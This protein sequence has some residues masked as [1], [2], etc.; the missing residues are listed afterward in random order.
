MAGKIRAVV[1]GSTGRGNYGHGLDTVFVGLEGI[2]LVAI[3]DND[4]QG[5]QAAG[6]RTGVQRLYRDYQEMFSK[7]KPQLAAIGPRHVDQRVAMVEAAAS[8]GCAVYC[9]KPLAGDLMDADRILVACA[10]AGVPIAVAHQTHAVPPVRQVL[11]NLRAG[12][13]GKLLRMRGRGKED[14]RGGGED[15]LVLGTHLMDLMVLFAGPPQWVSGHVFHQGRSLE[16]RDGR[17]PTE[18]VGI[19]G[20]DSLSATYGFAQ[21]VLGYFE[22]RAQVGQ[23]GKSPYGLILE[24]EQATLGIRAGEVYLYPAGTAIPENT[25]GKWEKVWVEDWHFFPDHKPRPS[26]W[27]PRGN[28]I[29]ARDLLDAMQHKREPMASGQAARWC[30]EM[31]LGVYAS[32]LEQGRRVPLPQTERRHPLRRTS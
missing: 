4:P 31:I 14:S 22:S 32:H 27:I 20:G 18:P 12:K 5:L 6:A 2:E 29:L 16:A 11:A 26:N 9:E 15:L 25:A 10:K 21:G 1:V 24:C 8:A 13:Y 17:Q 23:P 19:V 3:A 30:L 7:E 28:Q